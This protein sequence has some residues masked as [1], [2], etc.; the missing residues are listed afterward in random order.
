MSRLEAIL[1]ALIL[2]PDGCLEWP[3]GR[4]KGYGRVSYKGRFWFVHRL[5]WTHLIGPIPP[6]HEVHH[7]CRNRLCANPD[8]LR[9]LPSRE[10]Q[11]LH[12]KNQ[13][14]RP[15]APRP[16]GRVWRR[17]TSFVVPL[18][19]CPVINPFDTPA[20]RQEHARWVTAYH[21]GQR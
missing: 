20:W 10:H 3:H 2:S 14:L 8:H 5:L 13:V 12:G 18:R 6:G 4:I 7:A 21:E 17:P 11:K 1:E 19:P 9:V 15:R 16:W